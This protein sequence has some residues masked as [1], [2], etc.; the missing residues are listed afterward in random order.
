MGKRWAGGRLCAGAGPVGGPGGSFG[1]D[2]S[3]PL[4]LEETSFGVT[5][6]LTNVK[7]SDAST[8]RSTVLHRRGGQLNPEQN[9]LVRQESLLE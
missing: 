3:M 2:R 4:Q 8:G 9:R 1:V 7:D 6:V 5:A